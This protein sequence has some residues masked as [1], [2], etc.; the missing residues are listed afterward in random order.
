[1]LRHLFLTLFLIG[2]SLPS[3]TA[4]VQA[5]AMVTDCHGAMPV[6]SSHHQPDGDGSRAAGHVCI[7]C[8]ASTPTAAAAA[9]MPLPKILPPI[10]PM[11]EL[12][13]ANAPPSIPPPQP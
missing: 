9:P 2:L 1:M 10:L 8:I 4:P 6:D 11:T 7:G 13:S 12:A 5:E 3:V